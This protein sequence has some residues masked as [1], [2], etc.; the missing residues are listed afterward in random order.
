MIV[1][2]SLHYDVRDEVLLEHDPTIEAADTSCAFTI[3][4]T[5]LN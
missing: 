4:S 2:R 5:K 3:W 1:P